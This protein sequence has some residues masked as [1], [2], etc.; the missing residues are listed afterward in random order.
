MLEEWA[1]REGDLGRW[2]RDLGYHHSRHADEFGA[3]VLTEPHG[4][5]RGR[6]ADA[7]AVRAKL[8]RVAEG[9]RAEELASR[10]A[11]GDVLE[12]GTS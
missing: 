1:A 2:M 6:V 12:L 3:Y 5:W 10:P 7:A 9:E 4:F 11:C 8:L